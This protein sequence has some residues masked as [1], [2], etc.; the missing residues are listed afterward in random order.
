MS[1][2]NRSLN[3][4]FAAGT[5]A[6]LLISTLFFLVLFAS[7]FRGQLE[8]ERAAAAAQVSRLLQGSLENAMLKRDIPGLT[9]IVRRL[10]REPGILGVR[11][12]NP[13][14][15]VRFASD[16]A[17]L[18]ER[19]PVGSGELE[20]PTMRLFENGGG[21]SVLRSVNPVRNRPECLECHGSVAAK[22]VNGILYVDF[23]A[24]PI[25]REARATTL[26]LM[27]SGA[28]IV[29]INLAGGWWFIRGQVLRPLERLSEV[30]RRLAGGDLEARIALPGEDELAALGRRFDAMATSLREKLRELQ[31]KERFLQGLVDAI[32]DGIRV[33]DGD[34]R[35]VLS[36]VSYRRQLGYGESDPL[37]DRCYAASQGRTSP[38][39]ETLTLCPLKEVSAGGAPLR[40]VHRQRRADGGPLDVEVYAA[41]MDP[42]GEGRRPMLVESIRDLSHEVRFSH[43]QRLSELGRLAAGVAHEIHNPLSA[44]RMALHAAQEAA[45]S[46]GPGS[47]ALLAEYLALVDREVEKCAEVTERLLKLSVPPPAEPELVELDRV[48]QDTLRLLCWETDSRGVRLELAVEGAPLRVLATDSDLRMM[49][50]NLAQNACHAMPEGGSLKVSCTRSEGRVRLAFE[51]TGVGIE[52]AD[53]LRIFEPFFSRR[54]DGVAGTGLGLSITKAIV[55]G[56]G[57]TIEM[58]SEPGRGSRFRV[59]FPDADAEQ[60][61]EPGG[62]PGARW[63]ASPDPGPDPGPDSGALTAEG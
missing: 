19:L 55:E 41:P 40:V 11:I 44:V 16:P 42:G 50:L 21:Q 20:A 53:R 32:P 35:V 15:E 62:R 13:A 8:R 57:G 36:N 18:G 47:L 51:D 63:D 61:A 7:L 4:K 28:L 27:G 14:G 38:C 54:A 49:T 5:A 10:G 12:S 59:E 2:L 43:E 48:V 58:E 24:V 37:P 45:D 23:D 34:Y 31:E 22:P 52:P 39:P 46:T 6:G 17:W 3:R 56:H 1:W 29:L 30:S 60:S 9:E 26:L 33:I 25:D